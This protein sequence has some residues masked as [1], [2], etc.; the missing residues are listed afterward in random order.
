MPLSSKEGTVI[1]ADHGDIPL[2]APRVGDNAEDRVKWGALILLSITR[3][4]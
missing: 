2:I 3:D 4:L 1:C